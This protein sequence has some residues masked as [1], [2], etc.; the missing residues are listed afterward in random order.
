[1]AF[2]SYKCF[3]VDCIPPPDPNT[4][5]PQERPAD[6]DFYH[7]T[8]IWNNTNDGY[9]TNNLGGGSYGLPQAMDNVK[10]VFGK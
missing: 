3:Y 7:D 4:I 10:V 5:P 6:F 2:K 8:S 9:I 1:M